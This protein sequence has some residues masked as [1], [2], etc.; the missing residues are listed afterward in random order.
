MSSQLD[1]HG[2]NAGYVQELYERYVRSPESVDART[3]QYFD[4]FGAPPA[5]GHAEAAPA[6]ESTPSSAATEKIFGAANFA[7]AIRLFGHLNAQ[8]DPLGSAPISDP[9]LSPEVH[10]ITYDDLRALP[11]SMVG[12]PI[13]QTAANAHD[14][15]REL[16][17]VYSSR[18]GYDFDHIRQPKER[19][20]L[21]EAAESRRFRFNEGREKAIA[22]LERLTQVEGFETFLQ[23]TYPTKYRFSIEGLDMML[24]VLDEVIQ[25]S[26]RGGVE[27][28]VIGMAHRGRLNVL[29]HILNKPYDHILSEFKDPLS[30]Q[31]MKDAIGWT[32][33]DVK[34]HKGQQHALAGDQPRSLV[35]TLPPNPSHL[36]AIDPVVVGMARA[37][38]SSVDQP[39]EAIFDAAKT[40]QIMIHGDAAF[41]GQGIVSETLNLSQLPGYRTGG[42]LHVIA[43]NQLGFTTLPQE[44]RSTLYASDLAKGFK[45]PIVH[46]NAD[47][48]EA[49]IEVARMAFAYTAE[50]EKDFLIDLVGYRRYGHNELDEPGFTQPLMYQQIRGHRTVRQLW[51]QTLET[52]GVIDGTEA[53]ALVEKYNALMQAA[54]E[55]TPPDEPKRPTPPSGLAKQARTLVESA[56]LNALNDSL[57]RLTEAFNFY[58]KRLE[59]TFRTRRDALKTPDEATIDWATAEELAFATILE[60][61]IPIRLTGQDSERGTFSQRHAVLYDSQSGERFVPLQHLSQAKAAFEVRNSPLSEEAALGFEY[62][63]NVQSPGRLVLWEAQYGDFINGAQN[64]VDEFILSAREKWGETPS[65][66]LLLPHGYEGRGPDHSSARLERFLSLAAKTNVRIANPTTAAQYFHLLRRQA[67]LLQNDPLPLIVL[68]PKSLL[69]SKLIMSTPRE[70]A[71]GRWHAVIDDPTDQ[72]EA[73]RRLVL[74]S[75]K[76][77]YDLT[78]SDHCARYSEV[79][80]ARVEQLYRFPADDLRAVINRYPNIE[81]VVWAQEEP[82]NMGAWEYM[83]WR[84][85]RLT[86]DA[87]PVDYVGRRRSSSPAEGSTTA[88]EVNQSMIVE[89]AF[90]WQFELAAAKED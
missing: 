76:F 74:C 87:I 69:R 7:Q 79:A 62:G 80:I 60:E 86:G 18:I 16:E 73:I 77:Y 48:P 26:A 68:T 78:Q 46:V 71:E 9:E 51:A 31:E 2:P 41:P 47:D 42:T 30:V 66:A 83:G 82:K 11:A 61:G 4:R 8:L 23:K 21:R 64:I 28:I 75:G 44:S 59:S 81:Q 14:A 1:F 10:G 55:T 56:R 15:I 6:S 85:R 67:L 50:F 19:Q 90:N 88:H 12:G 54:N 35:L 20:W 40:M 65:L 52:R 84:L 45:V 24:P 22:L 58:S 36:E 17:A 39:G 70:L 3:R 34:Y 5:N 57:A 27:I 89:Y 38:G 13:A 25:L 32:T 53:D 29:A 37:A 43:N 72:P 63:Y 33:G 49:C